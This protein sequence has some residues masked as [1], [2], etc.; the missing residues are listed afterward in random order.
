MK[1]LLITLIAAIGLTAFGQHYVG[2]F[3]GNGA[4][5]TNITVV[6]NAISFYEPFGT[7]A[8][9][10]PWTI[11]IPASPGVDWYLGLTRFKAL[12]TGGFAFY[13]PTVAN[14]WLFSNP[15]WTR[16]PNIYASS[17]YFGDG[18]ALSGAGVAGLLHKWE[19]KPSIFWNSWYPASALYGGLANKVTDELVLGAMD[20]F[21]TNGM[22]HVI[23]II[24]LD[25]GWCAPTNA[26]DGTL[27]WNSTNIANITNLIAAIH[28]NGYRAGIYAPASDTTQGG[29]GFSPGM[30]SAT[31]VL[32]L[33]KVFASWGVDAVKVDYTTAG[34]DSVWNNRRPPTQ[35]AMAKLWSEAVGKSGRKMIILGADPVWSAGWPEETALSQFVNYLENTQGYGFSPSF[36]NL[37]DHFTEVYSNRLY[38]V[39]GPGHSYHQGY[40]YS[41]MSY[42]EL[43]AALMMDSLFSSPIGVYATVWTGPQITLITNQ[44]FLGVHGDEQWA[45]P[46]LHF[47]AGNEQHLWFKPLGTSGRSNAVGIVNWVVATNVTL[48][49]TNCGFPDGSTF[50]LR[51]VWTNTVTGPHVNTASGIAVGLTNTR[52]FVASAPLIVPGIVSDGGYTGNGAG[53]TNNQPATNLYQ[54]VN[55]EQLQQFAAGNEVYYFNTR[56]NNANA[57]VLDA[58]ANSTNWAYAAVPDV[59][60]NAAA[61]SADGTYVA[62]FA[63]E[64]TF[65]SLASGIGTVELYAFENSAGS[66]AITAEFYIYDEVTD[67]IVYEFNPSPAYQ[68]VPASAVPTKLTFSV[69]MSEYNTNSPFRVVVKIKV[70]EGGVNP[71]IRIVSGGAYP[72][73]MMFSQPGSA[74][75]KK[76]GDTMTGA[77][78]ATS[79]TGDGSGLTNLTG[80]GGGFW[81]TNAAAASSISNAYNVK[82]AKLTS[83]GAVHSGAGFYSDSG[84]LGLY[85]NAFLRA[86][87]AAGQFRVE[88]SSGSASTTLGDWVTGMFSTSAGN[89]VF[90]TNGFFRGFIVATNGGFFGPGM[91]NYINST[92]ALIGGVTINTNKV[93][94]SAGFS[95]NGVNFFLPATNWPSAND[96]VIVSTG[97]NNGAI[98]TKW[99]AQS[100]GTTYNLNAST[101]LHGSNGIQAA[102][103]DTNKIDSTFVTWVNSK[104]GVSGD[105]NWTPTAKGLVHT[106]SPG[107]NNAIFIGSAVD[108]YGGTFD[109]DDVAFGVVSTNATGA[110]Y[111]GVGLFGGDQ[112]TV[113]LGSYADSAQIW[114]NAINGSSTP[115]TTVVPLYINTNATTY[116]GAVVFQ[117]GTAITSAAQTNSGN[118]QTA[119]ANVTGAT[120]LTGDLTAT[121]SSNW[122]DNLYTDVFTANQLISTSLEAGTIYTGV[123]NQSGLSTDA[124]GK[125]ISPAFKAPFSTNYTVAATDQIICVTGTNQL[126]TLPNGTNGIPSGRIYSILL[127]STTGYGTAVITNANGVQT[128]RTAAALSET[129]TNGQSL[130]LLWDGANWR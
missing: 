95:A 123:T 69:P 103:I 104:S 28:T 62:V 112:A 41:D 19:K 26:L 67:A 36:T 79:F 22:A 108:Y 106:N 44:N 66:G 101:N 7:Y 16:A 5:L 59:W 34:S 75:V 86:Q 93:T 37:M 72:S 45:N 64:D 33:A 118:I 73:H 2:R 39:T 126:I 48:Y 11:G 40:I 92:N 88:Y 113:S 8:N 30:S 97:T 100:G 29:D 94:A 54:F 77:L 130:T 47:T 60:T 114:G 13:D 6:S 99:A 98:S 84:A 51:D 127:S 71:T 50:Y 110:S 117:G 78:S 115:N 102:T 119:T 91:T 18:S 109:S 3:T 68:D 42:V 74:Y 124:N 122:V 111:K 10:D 15:T 61:T 70:S 105:T 116:L 129:I 76:S 27:T 14:Q 82:A 96:N 49:A 23:D 12:S 57:V 120:T 25:D 32:K 90:G 31:N 121:G 85:V 21:R 20:T 83:A 65:T 63:T 9:T 89:I 24:W 43:S 87:Q 35:L 46:T 107:V 125:L 53:L 81:F 56:S 4:G 1:K 128:I 80:V 52:F 38:A 58:A 17:N 55:L